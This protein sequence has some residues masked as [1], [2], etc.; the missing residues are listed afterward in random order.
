M[1]AVQKILIT[2]ILLPFIL[3]ALYIVFLWAT[4]IDDKVT[5]GSK[6][7]F[8]IGLSKEDTFGSIETLQSNYPNTKIY[9]SYGHRAGDHITLPPTN[10]SFTKIQKH[11]QWELLLDGDGE[12]FNIIRL[13]FEGGSLSEIY[14]HRKYFEGP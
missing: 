14:R 3:I 12:F 4:Y 11:E 8:T 10:D 7:G 2:T 9:I 6:Y 13:Q 5:S 1:R